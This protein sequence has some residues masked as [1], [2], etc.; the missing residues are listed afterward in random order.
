MIRKQVVIKVY[1]PAGDYL[2]YWINA[3]FIG[4]TK[5]LN[6]GLSE[7]IVNVFE[8]FD[9]QGTELGLG[10]I[11]NIEISDTDNQDLLIYSGYISKYEPLITGNKEG[12]TI[13]LLG[14]Y[15]KLA[16]DLLKDGTTTTLYTDVTAGLTTTPS[17]S[18]AD[19]GLVLR[20][21]IDRYK[22]ETTNPK[23]DY[24]FTSLPLVSENA[25]AILEMKSYIDAIDLFFSIISSDY[26]W[27]VDE[28]GIFWLKTKPA[29]PT[30]TFV[31]GKHFSKIG[32]NRNMESIRNALL[33]WNGETE[34]SKIYK[35][36]EDAVSIAKY[37]RRLEKYYD[38]SVGDED[39]A[40]KLGER[41]LAENKDPSIQLTCE[42]ADNNLNAN[43][44]YDIESIQ[45]GDTCRFAGFDEQFADLLRENMLITKVA[46]S[47]DKVELTVEVVKSG[48]L[49]WNARLDKQ[50]DNYYSI[51]APDIYTT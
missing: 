26:N 24:T 37:G 29:T 9:Y 23:L 3:D 14:H 33:F 45:P 47:L 44:G 8:K 35:L 41:F 43:L 16:T 50:A 2:K 13:T 5:E 22:A 6:A 38:Y 25:L 1:N 10:N 18:S 4:F 34:G 42:I 51:G 32:V 46:Y 19:I 40:D 20:A 36:Y 15:T 12:I 27:Y 31:L 30:H 11:V 49:D 48:L 7:C 21:I 39:T 28:Y 17:G